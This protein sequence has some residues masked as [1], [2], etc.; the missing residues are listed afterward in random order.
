[1]CTGGVAEST[2]AHDSSSDPGVGHPKMEKSH[3]QWTNFWG[4]DQAHITAGKIRYIDKETSSMWEQGDDLS[5]ALGFEETGFRVIEY[6][7]RRTL[8]SSVLHG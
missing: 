2:L 8:R 3:F 6:G 5:V 1:M 7:K 4:A